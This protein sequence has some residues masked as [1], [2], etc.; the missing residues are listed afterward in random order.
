MPSTPTHHE[1]SEIAAGRA[2]MPPEPTR[3]R[4]EVLLR[5]E[6]VPTNEDNVSGA[7][8]TSSVHSWAALGCA[9]RMVSTRVP[10]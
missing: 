8:A 7:A 10:A 4:I 1:R 2:A 3:Y 9:A 6:W 5:S